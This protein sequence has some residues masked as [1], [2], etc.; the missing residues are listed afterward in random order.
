MCG[1][2][3]YTGKGDALTMALEGLK[4]LEYRGYDS[5]GVALLVDGELVVTKRAGKVMALEKAIDGL[6]HHAHLSLAHTR[7]ATHGPPSERN[8]HPHLDEG[9][10]LAL[11]HNGIIENYRELRD[12]LVAGGISFVSDTDTE[13]VAQLLASHYRGDILKAMQ[14]VLQ[15]L[16]GSFALALLHRDYPEQIIACTHHAPLIIGLGDEESFLSSDAQAFASYTRDV[17]YMSDGEIAIIHP[18]KAE[19]FSAALAPVDR[20]TV[21]LTHDIAET[22][23]GAYEHYTLKEIY[24]QPQALRQALHCR[25]LEEYG[26]ASF[27]ELTFNTN[28]L[29]GIQRILLVGCGT[30]W[31]AGYL[32][33]Y[34]FEEL[35]RL[36]AQVE[37]ASELR[38]KNPVVPAG[39]LVIAI[40]QSGETA[41]TLAA[42]RELK[43]KGVPTLALCN[44]A[45]STLSREADCTILLHAGPEIGVC[46]TKAFTSQV[47]VLALFAVQMARMRNLSRSEGQHFLAA[48]KEIP[49]QV[50]S[51]LTLAPQIA[52]VA[53]KYAH[54][55]EFFF[56]GRRYM[57]PTSMEGAL[58]L[59]EISYV[60]ANAY[61]AGE[62]K[63][64]PIALIDSECPTIALCNNR[65]TFDKLISNMMEIKARHGSIVAFADEKCYHGLED[66]VDD[67]ILLP[68]T[69][70]E[71]AA[72]P[73]AVATQL[74]AYY[75]A[76]ER[77]IDV[78]HPRNLAKSVT[79]E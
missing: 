44:V 57:Y 76:K 20:T 17:L 73:V 48:L 69:T 14:E 6:I 63:H 50:T 27:D 60:N 41:D 11:V 25:Y 15:L 52:E 68:S 49:D 2:F 64:G 65:Q 46:S 78:D 10:T 18:T 21:L 67:L 71:L 9:S 42:M 40:S 34:L 16:E 24:E 77:G 13:V 29:L 33:S 51:V 39:T 66:V 54:Y 22:S 30:S 23:K 47:A 43:A 26:T 59:K 55:E 62:M 7:W 70:D 31:H 45:G 5:A 28:E 56:I 8:A 75:I 53:K 72:F 19:L 32:G 74:F 79:V 3:G 4:R 38:Y 1:I 12:R 36:P 58:K 37:I 35:A 61:A